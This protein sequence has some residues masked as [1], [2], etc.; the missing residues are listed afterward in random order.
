MTAADGL[1]GD[2]PWREIN[3]FGGPVYG[4]TDGWLGLTLG[5][6]R[7][8]RGGDGRAVGL[9]FKRG[10]L[11]GDGPA[12]Y[13][14]T[15]TVT[16]VGGA[17]FPGF[18]TDHRERM[19]ALFTLANMGTRSSRQEVH[20]QMVSGRFNPL[21]P[22]S[23]KEIKPIR[24]I[25]ASAPEATTSTTLQQVTESDLLLWSTENEQVAVI[26][27]SVGLTADQTESASVHIARIDT[28]R[29]TIE[30]YKRESALRLEE[31]SHHQTDQDE[32]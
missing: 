11:N 30:R 10:A 19:A 27:C 4:L 23:G 32:L 16:T 1:L 18:P 9:G 14:E 25:T 22:L 20:T 28:D 7:F 12:L 21:D 17:G 3:D 31:M 24:S 2:D 15:L 13:V 26:V 6:M 29:E 5:P 8:S